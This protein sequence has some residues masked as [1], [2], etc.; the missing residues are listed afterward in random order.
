MD[1]FKQYL[2][3][4]AGELDTDEPRPLVWQKIQQELDAPKKITVRKYIYWAVAACVILLL[5]SMVWLVMKPQPAGTQNQNVAVVK[6]ADTVVAPPTTPVPAG[7]TADDTHNKQMVAV[8]E[9]KTGFAAAKPETEKP[10]PNETP[11]LHNLETGFIRVINMQLDRVRAMPLYAEG[12]QYFS[13]FKQ[14]FEALEQDEKALKKE[15]RNTGI[16]DEQL[17]ALI[18]IYQQK[19]NVLKQLQNEIHKT[20]NAY[21]QHQPVQAQPTPSFMNI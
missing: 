4:H 21:R 2:Q 14:Q 1:Q 8:K 17:D 13:S 11:V 5:G 15:I 10:L 12:P 7:L 3:Q 18:D 20:N 19:I 16:T 6:P 9:D